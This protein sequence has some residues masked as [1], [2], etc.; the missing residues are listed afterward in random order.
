[1]TS[2][3]IGAQMYSVRD[4][5]TTEAGI[6]ETLFALKAQGYNLCQLSGFTRE[7]APE[8]VAQ[9][10]HDSGMRCGSTHF[11]YADFDRDLPKI[12]KIH[13]LWDCPYPGLGAMP[14]E[15]ADGKK[16]GYL[17]FARWATDVAERLK[18]EGLQFIYHNHA[19]ELE[20]FG[21]AT[22]LELLME[23]TSPAVQFELDLFWIQAGGGS[24]EDWIERVRG[25]M[26]VV[27]FKEMTGGD[28]LPQMAP[29]GAGNMNWKR[30]MRLCDEIGVKFAFIEQDD[31]VETDSLSCMKQSLDYLKSIGGR[32]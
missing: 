6:R 17:A 1:M 21:G 26:D 18:A 7:A 11:G 15:F 8:A 2:Y 9:A 30:L 32:F 24:P 13:K 10:L 12:V 22:G 25:R 19:F 29:I 20:K 14:R 5:L 27:H 31:A 16:E 4:R 3:T 23:H 28:K